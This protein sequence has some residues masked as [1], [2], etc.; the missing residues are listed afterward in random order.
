V[1][2]GSGTFNPSGGPL[3]DSHGIWFGGYQSIYLFVPGV[4][5]YSAAAI[6]AQLAGPCA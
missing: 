1:I 3:A 6:G 5:M 2:A 4:G